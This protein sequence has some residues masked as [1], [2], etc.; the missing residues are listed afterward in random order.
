M[1]ILLINNF[2]YNRGGDCTYL[3]SLEKLLKR[4]GHKVIIFSM[5]HPSN[6]NSEYSKYFVSYIDYAKEVTNKTI[7]S[8]I[9]VLKRTVY[10]GEA[11]K[12]IEAL[13]REEKPDIAH[14]QNI[15]HHIT[16]SI[17]YALRKNNIPIVWTLHDYTIIC[18][19]TSF[20]AHNTI[21]ER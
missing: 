17:F 1:K 21:C 18:P 20:L 4:K 13:I 8:G 12:K 15:H 3:L 9:K 16:P 11:K 2:Y 6:F 5:N 14:L 7:S 19:N 10:S